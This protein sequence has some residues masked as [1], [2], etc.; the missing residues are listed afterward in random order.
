MH[1]GHGTGLRDRQVAPGQRVI[2]VSSRGLGERTDGVCQD[3]QEQQAAETHLSA[4][5][6]RVL[7]QKVIPCSKCWAPQRCKNLSVWGVCAMGNGSRQQAW[8]HQSTETLHLEVWGWKRAV[9]HWH[10]LPR[11][12]GDH[13]D[14]PQN[15][16]DLA[17]RDGVGHGG[18]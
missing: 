15:R 3:G 8:P 7:R 12:R 10:G 17:L 11:E 1:K 4:E 5:T 16:G 9:L 18:I 14:V 6:Q 13:L 2:H